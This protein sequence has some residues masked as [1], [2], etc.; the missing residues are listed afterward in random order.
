MKIYFNPLL[1]IQKIGGVKCDEVGCGYIDKDV[2]VED[3]PVYLNTPCPKCG[4]ILLTEDDYAIVKIVLKLEKWLG[5]IRVPS[6]KPPI[7]ATAN[8]NGTGTLNLDIDKTND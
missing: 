4:A 2:S 7:S 6:F 8:M 5:W 3:Y 1:K